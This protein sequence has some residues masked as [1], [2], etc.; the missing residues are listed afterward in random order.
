VAAG[1]G[2][3][4]FFWRLDAVTVVV[5]SPKGETELSAGRFLVVFDVFLLVTF[6]CAFAAAALFA[7]CFVFFVSSKSDSSDADKYFTALVARPDLR[8]DMI[9]V[10]SFLVVHETGAL[11][12]V[13]EKTGVA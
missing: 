2:A 3:V 7:A 6:P 5:V 4:A 13:D 8:V 1:V 10:L 12:F 9:C 11:N